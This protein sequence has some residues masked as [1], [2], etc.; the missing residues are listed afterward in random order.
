VDVTGHTLAAEK[1]LIIPTH[2]HVGPS[3]PDLFPGIAVTRGAISST[4]DV[5]IFGVDIRA[6]GVALTSLKVIAK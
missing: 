2:G 5:A 6:N 1:N 4:S 3:L